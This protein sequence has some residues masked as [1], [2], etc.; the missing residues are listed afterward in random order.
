MG[1][2]MILYNF[3]IF[4]E[5]KNISFT[6]KKGEIFIWMT[7]KVNGNLFKNWANSLLSKAKKMSLIFIIGF[8]EQLKFTKAQLSLW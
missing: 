5:I 4:N 8:S 3:I 7:L 1:L 6:E 2:M